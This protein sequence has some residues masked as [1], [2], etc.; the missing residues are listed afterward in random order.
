MPKRKACSVPPP[1]A[2]TPSCALRSAVSIASQKS[3]P[4]APKSEQAMASA[5][6]K[7]PRPTTLIQ[8]SAQI[9]TSTERTTSKTRFVAKRTRR[10]GMALRAARNAAGSASTAAV[11]VPRKAMASVSPSA[12]TKPTSWPCGEGGIIR[13]TK[14]PSR[15]SPRQI[16]KG[17][18]SRRT[19]AK[20]ASAS[21]PRGTAIASARPRTEVRNTSGWRARS[22][23]TSTARVRA[24][25]LMR[26]DRSPGAGGAATACRGRSP[27]P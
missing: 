3:L 26:P 12:G 25:A 6:A 5:P 2:V 14:S 18:K 11:S 16:R 9:S 10:L 20:S 15:D 13:T 1:E 24:V 27:S 19:S 8:I 4:K 7:G 22:A 17:S 21:M 23:A